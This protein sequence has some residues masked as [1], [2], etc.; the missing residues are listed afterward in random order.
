MFLPPLNHGVQFADS[1][2]MNANSLSRGPIRFLLIALA[3]AALTASKGAGQTSKLPALAEWKQAAERGDPKAQ[4][5][6]GDAYLAQQDFSTAAKWYSLAAER[7][8]ATAQCSLGMLLLAGKPSTVI[9]YAPVSG[10]PTNAIKWLQRAANQDNGRAQAE[11]GHCYRD[12]KV[13]K[14]DW[15]EAYKWYS[16]AARKASAW[17]AEYRDP[18]ILKMPSD[19]ILEGQR[20]VDKFIAGIETPNPSSAANVANTTNIANTAS[21]PNAPKTL[22]VPNASQMEIEP[23]PA[24]LKAITLKGILQTQNRRLA[25]INGYTFQAGD[26]RELR[27][28]GKLVKVRCLEIREDSV[29]VSF[30]GRTRS[31]ELAL[32]GWRH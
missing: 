15:A 10:D 7:G 17:G 8:I 6:L 27:V 31:N 14:R 19:Q 21:V 9:G 5:K 16:L 3:L 24:V 32:A 20:R 1:M 13:V 23:D 2:P 18:L 26:E 30:D 29:L 25:L 22:N 28:N 12:G 11:L 4:D